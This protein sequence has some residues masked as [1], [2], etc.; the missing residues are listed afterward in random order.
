MEE[1]RGHAVDAL[2]PEVL[3]CDM[4]K[5]TSSKTKALLFGI[6]HGGHAES[7][8][9]GRWLHSSAAGVAGEEQHALVEMQ[10]ARNPSEMKKR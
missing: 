7:S 1:G 8:G 10:I 2:G 6:L 9:R 5:A 4:L 3:V